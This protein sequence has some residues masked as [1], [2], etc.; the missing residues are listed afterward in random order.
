MRYYESYGIIF[1][2]K[3]QKKIEVKTPV[4]LL[5]YQNARIENLRES[6]EK[7]KKERIKMKCAIKTY[8]EK[9]KEVLTTT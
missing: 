9:E 7:M 2:S 5:N 4:N 8:K 6:V 3:H 1:D